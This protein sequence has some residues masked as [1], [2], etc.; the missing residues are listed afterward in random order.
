MVAA[1]E[2]A[3]S[4]EPTF[5]T[6]VAEPGIG[7]SRLVREFAR[8]VD[9]L[10][11]LITWREGRCLPY[12]EGISFWALGEIVKTHAGILDTDDQTEISHK[13]D[14]VLTEPDA[15]SRAWIKDRLAPLVGLASTTAAPERS[16][17]FAAWRRFLSMVAS[18]DPLVLLFEDLHW[19]DDVLVEFLQEL[20]GSLADL[21]V[22]VIATARPEVAERHPTWLDGTE[23]RL[24]ELE[25]APMR[26]LVAA[27][28]A[29]ASPDFVDAVCERAGGSPLYAEQLAAMRRTMPI[30]GGSED[31]L[32]I[33]P[34]VQALLAARIDLLPAELHETLLD[35]SVVGKTFW[36]GTVETLGNIDA[37]STSER[38]AEL[39]RR[40]F[41]R[42]ERTSTIEGEREYAFVHALMRDVTYGRLARRPR[43]AKHS[44]TAAWI[45]GQVGHP[46]GDI[47]EIVVAHLDQAKEAAQAA[48]LDD[49]LAPLDSALVDALTDA[50]HHAERTDARTAARLIERAV[51]LVPDDDPRRPDVLFYAAASA[52]NTGD[53]LRAAELVDEAIPGLRADANWDDLGDALQ[54]RARPPWPDR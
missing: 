23:R 35:A 48:G 24:H 7:K 17:L 20:H 29:G 10:P 30:A 5:L 52:G 46:L 39:E 31:D 45:T 42:A 26:E 3:R 2:R 19:A 36:A 50:A 25:A 40:E 33:P 16:E 28:L 9:D 6:I 47:A 44:A 41:V 34:S 14:A 38:L 15:S 8:Y 37:S 54:F 12:G 13:L 32:P 22:L 18:T 1:F 11:D 53:L 21:A 27:T 43:F 51:E 49:E 4:G